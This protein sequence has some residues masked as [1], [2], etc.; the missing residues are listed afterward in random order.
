[1]KTE[2][3][4]RMT[5][6]RQI[7]LEELRSV[8]THPT[9]ADLC[10]M[11]RKRMPRISL[12][13]VYRNLEILCRSGDAAKIDVA[14]HEMRFDAEVA[15][16]YHVR[17]LQCGRVA[18]LDIKPME[19]LEQGLEAHCDFRVTGHRMEFFGVCAQCYQS[20]PDSRP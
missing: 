2:P 1:M 7:I 15:N 3:R 17:C 18:D 9:A 4:L 16:H 14:G 19:G 13:T 8:K 12:G 20:E 6:Q 11:V 10:V 5:K